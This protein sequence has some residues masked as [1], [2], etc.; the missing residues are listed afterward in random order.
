MKLARVVCQSQR[1]VN[2]EVKQT[3]ETVVGKQHI[4]C[5]FLTLHLLLRV[6]GA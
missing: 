6:I 1:D 3:I 2:D 4:V 5:I